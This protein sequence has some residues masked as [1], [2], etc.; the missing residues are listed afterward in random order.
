VQKT[1]SSIEYIVKE[2]KGKERNT[3]KG[4]RILLLLKIKSSQSPFLL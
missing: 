3:E 4:D 1:V 2:R